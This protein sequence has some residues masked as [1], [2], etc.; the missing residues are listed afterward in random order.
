M[1]LLIREATTSRLFT[2]TFNLQNIYDAKATSSVPIESETVL[3][4]NQV[5]FKTRK[6]RRFVT[7]FASDS[8]QFRTHKCFS[9]QKKKILKTKSSEPYTYF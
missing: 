9:I 2:F 1:H 8:V 6:T 7:V 3:D 4:K 5:L